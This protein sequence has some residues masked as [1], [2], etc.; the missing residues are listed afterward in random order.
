MNKD[1]E[2]N[3]RTAL[4]GLMYEADLI[5]EALLGKKRHL[6]A[7][8][9]EELGPFALALRRIADL[10]DGKPPL[11]VEAARSDLLFLWPMLHYLHGGFSSALWSIL[12][13]A[14]ELVADRI[15]EQEA[16]VLLGEEGYS[17]RLDLDSRLGHLHPFEEREDGFR[18][19]GATYLERPAGAVS[20]ARYEV[21]ARK[22]TLESVRRSIKRREEEHT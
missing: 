10:A 7:R 15:S 20:Y 17:V 2:L 1:T 5:D 19:Y 18:T 11:D 8:R 16:L 9:C 4:S 13:R 14:H 6:D 3:M 21:E 12:S 22:R